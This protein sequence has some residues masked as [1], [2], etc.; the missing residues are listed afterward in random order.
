MI[1]ARARGGGLEDRQPQVLAKD[2]VLL[3]AHN[4]AVSERGR[5]V[6]QRVGSLPAARGR[7][8]DLHVELIINKLAEHDRV[9]AGAQ[10]ALLHHVENLSDVGD[11]A[12]EHGCAPVLPAKT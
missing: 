5:L 1:A 2:V 9:D 7:R 8:A 10:V 6:G 4:F 12:C 3:Q 11:D